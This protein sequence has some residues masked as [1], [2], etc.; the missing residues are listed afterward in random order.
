MLD[1]LSLACILCATYCVV[2]AEKDD[3]ITKTAY[4]GENVTFQCE[5]QGGT[6]LWQKGR[7]VT[8]F[9]NDALVPSDQI[10]VT[11]YELETSGAYDLTLKMV[12]V[13]DKGRY[14]CLVRTGDD[15]DQPVKVYKLDV[16]EG[17][18]TTEK[19]TA[20]PP[21]PVVESTFAPVVIDITEPSGT[22]ESNEIAPRK[23]DEMGTE[24]KTDS[25]T[26]AGKEVNKAETEATTGAAPKTHTKIST[27]IPVL[28]SFVFCVFIL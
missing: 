20:P 21:A 2:T 23:M 22:T 12:E 9:E 14:S 19:A 15:N 1:S 11:K 8:I 6:M 16:Q 17:I 13:D 5:Q 24:E 3:P 26:R 28:V 4:A 25:P 27:L 18:R 10:Q 7:M